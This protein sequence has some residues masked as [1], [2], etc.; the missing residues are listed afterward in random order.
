MRNHKTAL[1]MLVLLWFF[2][3]YRWEQEDFNSPKLRI[4][5]YNPG[6]NPR[7]TI[8][9]QDGLLHIIDNGTVKGDLAFPTKPWNADPTKGAIVEARIK[10]VDC[11]GECG[12]MLMVADGVHEDALTLYKDKIVLSKANLKYAMDTTNDFHI[13]RIEIRQTDIIVSV[14]GKPVITGKGK[15]THPAYAQRNCFGY[16]AGSSTAT[17]EAYWDWIRWT[18]FQ[19]PIDKPAIVPGAENII[20]YKKNGMYACFPSLSIDPDTGYLYTSFGTRVKQTHIDPTGGTACMESNDGGRTW[21]HIERIPPNAVGE[22][23]GSVFTTRDGAL[24]EIGHYFWRRYPAVQA[25]ELGK[26]YYLYMNCGPGPDKVATCTGGYLRRSTD[27]GKTWEKK[28]IPELDAYMAASSGWSYAQLPDGT[29]LRAFSI[30]KSANDAAATYVVRTI[31]GKSYEIVRAIADP[32]RKEEMT[33]ESWMHV[34]KDGGVWILVRAE[35]G[36]DR[37]W[38][39]FSKDGGKTW[40]A[41]KTGIKGH[42]PSSVIRLQDGRLLLT[43]GYRHPPF[44]I[45]AVVSEDDGKTWRA[46]CVFVLRADG[47][48]Y[49]LGYPRS[50]QLKDGTV[51]TIYYFVTAD[52]ITH[53]ACTR[54]RVP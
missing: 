16:G 39:A 52:Y 7:L 4:P 29:I 53:I 31:D 9:Q 34:M 19:A 54:W 6:D 51:V 27:G 35:R 44:G 28:E 12:V 14:D 2:G 32:E 50:V 38:Q 40:R 11:Q 25:K 48:N 45:R 36:D 22:R 8:T 13:Y 37:M 24:V 42:P 26:K 1:L 5:W 23:P 20:V 30:K 46:D 18:S 33:E 21:H 15:F 41:V 49:D 17:G 3:C 10:V 47:D 43:Y